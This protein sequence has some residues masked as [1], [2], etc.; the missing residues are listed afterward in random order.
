MD[1]EEGSDSREGVAIESSWL[2]D[3]VDTLKGF[4][5]GI[6]KIVF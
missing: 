3:Q 2:C 5:S 4:T 1:S 6:Q